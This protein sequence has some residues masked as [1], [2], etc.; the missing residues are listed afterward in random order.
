MTFSYQ[1]D[2]FCILDETLPI[3]VCKQMS[4]DLH[5]WKQNASIH[6][7]RYGILAHNL[8]AQRPLFQEVLKQFELQK[9]AEQVYGGP[10]LFFQDNLI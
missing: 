5:V 4:D 3:Q 6:P 7:N 2:G 10:L 9:I 1:Q 8:F